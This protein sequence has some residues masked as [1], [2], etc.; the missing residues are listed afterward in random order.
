MEIRKTVILSMLLALSV[1]LS[2]IESFIPIFNGIIP[3]M[4]IGLANILIV[5]SLYVYGFKDTVFLAILRVLLVGILRTGIFSIG[6]FLSLSGGVLSI[7]MMYLAKKTKL[8]IIGVSIIG[9]ISH[10]VGQI[11][12]AVILLNSFNLIY[13]LP[14]LFIFSI[15]TGSIIGNISKELIKKI[16]NYCN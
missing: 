15:I 12:M 10:S 13:Y 4:K 11:F 2:I 9:A 5:Y 3:G 16:P 6:F 1:V 14:Y 7:F 8:S